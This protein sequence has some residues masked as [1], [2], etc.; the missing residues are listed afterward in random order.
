MPRNATPKALLALLCAG[1]ASAHAQNLFFGSA[2]FNGS[3][4]AI[5][6]TDLNGGGLHNILPSP[7]VV[8]GVAADAGAGRVFW[9]QPHYGS[10]QSQWTLHAANLNGSGHTVLSTWTQ[11]GGNT[12]GVAADRVNQQLYWTDINGINRSNYNGTG[13]TSLV[14]YHHA[15]DVEV[16]ASAN[17]LFWTGNDSSGT[18]GIWTANLNGSN[19]IA[20]ATLPA[21]T[22]VYGLTVNPG[23]QTVYWSNSSGGQISAIP[24]AGGTPTTIL[25]SSGHIQGLEYEATTNR[26]YMVDKVGSIAWMPPTGGPVTTVFTG[27]GQTLGEMHDIAAVVPAP[28][29][30]ALLTFGAILSRRRRS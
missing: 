26:L 7:M 3:Q 5:Y 10:G 17:R 12:Y 16:D 30:V 9:Q 11:N 15:T 23:T 20:L 4:D 6:S 27:S 28:G 1:A 14:S 21:N 25:S 29:A 2:G 18:V 24:Y 19:P 22:G 13:A 8:S